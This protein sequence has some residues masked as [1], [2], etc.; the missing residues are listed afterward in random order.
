MNDGSVEHEIA[1]RQQALLQL[2]GKANRSERNRINRELWT[3]QQGAASGQPPASLPSAAPVAGTAHPAPHVMTRAATLRME[4]LRAHWSLLHG[5]EDE[6]RFALC[7]RCGNG[8]APRCRFHPDAK[9]FAFGTG[10]FDFGYTTAWDTP[11]DIW[12]CCGSTSPQCIGCC[13][14][15]SHTT[16]EDWWQPYAE[17]GPSLDES[18]TSSE[19]ED[20]DEEDASSRPADTGGRSADAIAGQLAAMEID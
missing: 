7:V 19:E 12:F 15:E 5:E 1:W 9:A 4:Q 18:S 11:H 13:E 17:L 16:R 10:R 2:A 3:L 14:E 6:G 8:A 20:D